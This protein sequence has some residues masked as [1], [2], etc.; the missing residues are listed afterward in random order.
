MIDKESLARRLEPVE[1]PLADVVRIPETVVEP[2]STPFFDRG[3]IESVT[4]RAPQR[5][6]GFTVGL[7]NDGF[8]SVL[9]NNQAGYFQLAQHAGL[10][11]M[12]DSLR[13]AYV[14]AF[15]NAIRDYSHRFQILNRFDDIKL[16]N[17]PTDDEKKQYEALRAKYANLIR[18]P[19]IKEGS[20]VQLF[21]VKDRNLAAIQARLSPSGQID[22]AENVLEK[23]IP[24]SFV[25]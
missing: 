10:R 21:A 8:T 22:V 7:A 9:T 24:V 23:E 18:P 4:T 6:F 12:D 13:L 19:V 14:L 5:P 16:I 25:R 2:F 15:F 17:Q 20:L 3:I 11:L 1:K